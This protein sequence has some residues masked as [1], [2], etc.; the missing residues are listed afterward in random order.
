MQ[1]ARDVTIGIFAENLCESHAER[2]A[3]CTIVQIDA[4]DGSPSR[5]GFETDDAMVCDIRARQGSPRDQAIGLVID[6]FG[7]PFD[8]RAGRSPA[9]LEP[10]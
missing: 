10:V 4:D 2:S 7:I 8:Q 5:R 3:R 6:D 1:Y 9:R